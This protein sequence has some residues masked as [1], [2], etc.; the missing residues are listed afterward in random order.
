MCEAVIVCRELTFEEPVALEQLLDS[1]QPFVLYH[2][3]TRSFWSQIATIWEWFVA[4]FETVSGHARPVIVYSRPE[5]GKPSVHTS[6]VTITI[7]PP[8]LQFEKLAIDRVSQ[9]WLKNGEMVGYCARLDLWSSLE[10]IQQ[11]ERP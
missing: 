7:E 10:F 2:L 5:G 3:Q 8:I 9:E 4:N 1:Q 6:E 11:W